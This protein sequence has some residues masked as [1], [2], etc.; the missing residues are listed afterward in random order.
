MQVDQ[1]CRRD[2]QRLDR[3]AHTLGNGTP[4]VGAA[5]GQDHGKLLAAIAHDRVHRPH[6]VAQAGSDG[7]QYLVAGQMAM[8]IVDVLEVVD[9][10]Q[11]QQ[12]GFTGSGHHLDC[13]FQRRDEVPSVAQACQG[14]LE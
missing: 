8:G 4:A 12:D 7:L 10:E 5:V 13:A 6:T 14:I 11:Q 2:G 3:A 9:V 1:R